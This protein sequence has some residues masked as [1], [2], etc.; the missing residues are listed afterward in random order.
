ME[1]KSF[2]INFRPISPRDLDKLVRFTDRWIGKGYFNKEE[3]RTAILKGIKDDLNAGFVSTVNDSIVG[4]RITYAPGEW[5]KP[6]D[7]DTLSPGAW[8]VDMDKVAYFKS[9]FVHARFQQRGIGS[10][11]SKR[12]KEVLK[13]MGAEAIV[14]HAWVESPQN[15]SRKYLE[16]A[17]FKEVNQHRKFWYNVDYECTRCGADSRCVC[18]AAEMICLLN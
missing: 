15:S 1:E 9:L 14:T 11:L 12:S 4:V 13:E 10:R 16:K 17:G 8:G 7:M 2:K 18:T 5:I 6:K 3:L